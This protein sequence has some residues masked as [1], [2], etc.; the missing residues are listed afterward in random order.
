MQSVIRAI[1]PPQ[2]LGCETATDSEGGLCPECWKDATFIGGTICDTC[3]APL[4]GET[5]G[6]AVQCDDCMRIARPWSRGRAALAYRKTGRRLVLGLKHGDRTDLVPHAA[7]WMM[8]QAE[9]LIGPDT[10]LIPVPLHWPRLLRRRYNQ[11]ALL[12]ARLAQMTAVS[13]CPDALIRPKRTRMLDGHSREARFKALNG[14][15]IPNPRRQHILSGSKVV[16]IDDVMTTGATLA[17]AAEAARAG[18]AASIDILTL[19]R[20]VKDA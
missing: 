20:V 15:I 3:G 1:Y 2:C 5:D 19:A 6:H 17:A 14:A 10:L 13:H 4:V 16:L 12:A 18:G 9:D 8:K 11:A 7:H